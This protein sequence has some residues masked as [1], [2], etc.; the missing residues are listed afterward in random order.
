MVN[1]E[2]YCEKSDAFLEQ[3]YEAKMKMGDRF[4]I[5]MH[6][7]ESTSRSNSELYD[8]ILLGSK[9]IG[10]GFNLIMHPDLIEVVKEKDI[11]LESCPISNKVLGYCH[12]LRTHPIRSLLTHGVKVTISSDDHGFWAS[13]GVTLDYMVA[14]LAWDLSLRDI[15]QL[16]INSIDYASVSEE[17]KVEL[18]KFFEYKWR[19]FLAY[20]RGKY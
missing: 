4:N 11:C 3:I 8:A 6:A 15:K 1:E 2:D 9:R 14:Y 5:F 13:P 10:H 19:I 16:L 17:Y 7:G 20:V 18:R 12:D